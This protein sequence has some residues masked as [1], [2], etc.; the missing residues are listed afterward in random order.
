[1]VV[2]ATLV[3]ITAE[4]VAEDIGIGR[5]LIMSY[6]IFLIQ[7]GFALL[8]AGTV[9][10]V[11][12]HLLLLVVAFW[13]LLWCGWQPQG[14]QEGWANTLCFHFTRLRLK[15]VKNILLKNVIG[16]ATSA[17]VWFLWGF[18][19]AWAE[20]GDSPFIG[21]SGFLLLDLGWADSTYDVTYKQAYAH[22][23]WG[24]CGCVQCVG[25]EI[26]LCVYNL[27]HNTHDRHTTTH[28]GS[29]RGHSAP[30]PSRLSAVPLPSARVS[31][32]TC[33]TPSYCPA[34]SIQWWSTGYGRS[35]AGCRVDAWW[36]ARH[37][38]WS[39]SLQGR[40]VSWT[41]R[42]GSWCTS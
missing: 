4:I 21:Y 7:C 33:S 15:N 18:A 25:M 2:N 10:C 22:V 11:A 17:I 9:R 26:V 29:T 6:L 19:F 37:C 35:T 39:R 27:A 40:M 16:I 3:P 32:P 23:R 24:P 34:L 38:R 31:E 5:L 13:W 41:L 28:S 20:C 8:E 12:A 1:M 42:G 36:I 14:A 30:P